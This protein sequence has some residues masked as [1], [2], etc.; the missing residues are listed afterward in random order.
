MSKNL[1]LFLLVTALNGFLLLVGWGV[2]SLFGRLNWFI[3]AMI[4]GLVGIWVAVDIAERLRL[5]ERASFSAVTRFSVCG[6]GIAA[7]IAANNEGESVVQLASFFLVG[8]GALFGKW[9]DHLFK[10]N[11]DPPPNIL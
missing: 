10:A 3:G 7:I 6:F 4:G 9:F 1:L 5:V 11:S 8:L 2:G